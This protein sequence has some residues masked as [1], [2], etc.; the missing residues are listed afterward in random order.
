MLFADLYLVYASKIAIR[1]FRFRGCRNWPSATATVTA[2]P[3]T[4]GGW[5]CPTVE[6]PYKYHIDGEPYTGLHEEP[7]LLANSLGEYI[8][9]FHGWNLD[10][11]THKSVATFQHLVPTLNPGS[12]LSLPDLHRQFCPQG[13]SLLHLHARAVVLL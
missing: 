1:F 7:F 13:R 3:L 4:T 11:R 12:A 9:Q 5:G 2:L 6:I 8:A 10:C